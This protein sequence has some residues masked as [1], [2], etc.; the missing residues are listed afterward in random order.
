MNEKDLLLKSIQKYEGEVKGFEIMLR[1][2]ELKEGNISEYAR[3]RNMDVWKKD[4]RRARWNLTRC[5]TLLK[6]FNN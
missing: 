4:L 6:E 1:R 3:K 2:E 5:K